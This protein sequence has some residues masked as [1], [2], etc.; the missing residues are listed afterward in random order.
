MAALICIQVLD[1][2]YIRTQ[3]KYNLYLFLGIN[4]RNGIP[5]RPIRLHNIKVW[6]NPIAS[7]KTPIKY[8]VMD[9]KR[10][11]IAW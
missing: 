6:C 2:L 9:R 3:F 11:L 5:A 7:P 1:R 4:S 10:K 8:A